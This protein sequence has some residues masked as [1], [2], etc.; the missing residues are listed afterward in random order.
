MGMLFGRGFS[1]LGDVR[2]SFFLVF[3]GKKIL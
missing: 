2:L 1:S 3:R